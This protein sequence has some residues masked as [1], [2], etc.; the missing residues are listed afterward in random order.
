MAETVDDVN[1]KTA[2]SVVAGEPVLVGGAITMDSATFLKHYVAPMN[3]LI[4]KRARIRVGC[5]EGCDLLVQK[6]CSERGYFDVTVYIPADKKDDVNIESEQFDTIIVQGKFQDR[7]RKMQEGCNHFIGVLSQYAGAAS[8]TAANL[9]S[10]AAK[11]GRFGDAQCNCTT[12]DGY[13]IV[14]LLRKYSLPFDKSLQKTIAEAE[15]K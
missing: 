7:D 14:A 4:E 12:L 10:M 1:M 15:K 2:Q 3:V 11:A 9:I 13:A 5:A 8:G 6:H